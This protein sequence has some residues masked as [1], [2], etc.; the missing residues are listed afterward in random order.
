MFDNLLVPR[1]I[2]KLSVVRSVIQD[3]IIKRLLKVVDSVAVV[4]GAFHGNSGIKAIPKIVEDKYGA[5]Q[6]GQLYMV[7]NIGRSM[8]ILYYQL[9]NG[10]KTVVRAYVPDGYHFYD[11]PNNDREAI[12][13]KDSF[14]LKLLTIVDHNVLGKNECSQRIMKEMEKQKKK[15]EKQSTK[16]PKTSRGKGVIYL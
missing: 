2:E 10:F 13:M 1:G 6:N 9:S 7:C 15:A 3:I 11:W 8:V 14:K 12:N 4:P 16:R 5:I